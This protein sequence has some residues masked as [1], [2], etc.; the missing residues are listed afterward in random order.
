MEIIIKLTTACNLRCSYCS[1]GN[2]RQVIL[3]KQ[4]LYKLID[5]LSSLLDKCQDKDID[6]LWHGGEPLLVGKTFLQEA[7]QYAQ[8]K[9]R[10][11]NLQFSLQ[12]NGVLIDDEWIAI[13]K[14]FSVGVGVSLDG[15]RELHDKSRRT[16]DNKPTFDVVLENLDKMTASGIMPGVLMVLDAAQPIDSDKL[17][18]MIESHHLSLKIHPMIPTGRAK[19]RMDENDI[20]KNYIELMKVLYKRCMESEKNVVVQP[21]DAIMDAIL[22]I[23]DLGECSFSGCCGTR[24]LCLYAD[25]RI[26]FCG[27]MIDSQLDFAYGNLE[28]TPLLELYESG[29]ANRVRAR[30]KYLRENDCKGCSDW[31]LC[32]GGCTFETL[33]AFDTIEARH[34]NCI[35]RRQLIFFLRTDGLAML[36][37]KLV[38]EKRGYRQIIRKRGALMEELT[39][40]IQ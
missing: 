36:K 17:F 39:D 7:M 15:Y 10:G 38:Q 6:I 3:S 18:E 35:L 20:Y 32:H 22:G 16:I 12:T 25:G 31:K 13:F 14:K 30:V 26:G 40:A 24:F 21:L 4:N 29:I 34:P 1:E 27:R 8:K 11:Y 37:K 28:N 19:E 23:K 9:L 5:E 33:N 2:Q